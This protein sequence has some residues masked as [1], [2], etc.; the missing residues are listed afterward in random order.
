MY[1]VTALK[2]TARGQRVLSHERSFEPA[3]GFAPPCVG[4]WGSPGCNQ[5]EGLEHEHRPF[6]GTAL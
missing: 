4:E 5:P 3:R 6:V 2:H 1:V